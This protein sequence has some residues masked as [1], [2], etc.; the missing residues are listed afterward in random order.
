MN[1]L[2]ITCSYSLDQNKQGQ[3]LYILIESNIDDTKI[4]RDEVVNLVLNGM[5][6]RD[7]GFKGND[8]AEEYSISDDGV[9]TKL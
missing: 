1:K 9:F 8:K 2:N 6:K 7:T 3:Q 4:F 5:I